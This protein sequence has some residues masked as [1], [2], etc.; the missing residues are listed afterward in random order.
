M[1]GAPTPTLIV[2]SFGAS[3]GGGSITSPIPKASTGVPG[4]ASYDT[5]FPPITMI[6]VTAG[7]V[8]PFGQDFNGI[9]KDLSSNIAALTGGQQYQF[10]AAF[11]AANGGYASGAVL[12]NA[13]NPLAYWIN[14]V[15]GNSNNPDTGGTGWVSGEIAIGQTL[16][17]AAAGSLVAAGICV[18]G[19]VDRYIKNT[20]PGS[21]DTTGSLTPGALTGWQAAT[22]QAI[23]P[24]GADVTWDGASWY[25]TT[26]PVNCTFT[27][28]G[29]QVGI[30]LYPSGGP[31]T[32]AGHGILAN[33]TGVAV[34]DFTGCSKAALMWAA[35]RTGSSHP[36]TAVL[37]ARGASNQSSFNRMLNCSIVGSFTDSV[38]YN[39]G[40]EQNIVQG[41]ILYN[42]ST[43]AG[44]C[45]VRL[46]ANNMSGLTSPYT[47]IFS[48]GLSTTCHYHSGNT[49]VNSAGTS[50][51]DCVVFD[52]I[53]GA[54]F[55]ECF[56]LSASSSAAGRAI[57]YVYG[58]N[59]TS[60]R[61]K[62]SR[63]QG[64]V[65]TFMHNYGVLF[66]NSSPATGNPQ[67]V[68]WE[69]C[70]SRLTN[71]LYAIACA[72]TT[73]KPTNLF[74]RN[75]TE[76]P[77]VAH[78]MN[79]PGVLLTSFIEDPALVLTIGTSQQ[80]CLI[81]DSNKWGIGTAAVGGITTR[82]NDNWC[83]TGAVNKTWTPALG[84]VTQSGTFAVQTASWLFTGSDATFDCELNSTGTFT[85][86]AGQTIT[87][88]VVAAAYASANVLICD[89]TSGALLAT[90][91][92]AAGTTAIKCTAFTTSS[93]HSIVIS[94][95][96][97]VA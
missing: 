14:M 29:N 41:N 60:N 42:L 34:F 28:G 67:P 70:D 1:A 7:G 20:T 48:G 63:M 32:D 5:G 61:I 94:G 81:G 31:A 12:Q 18:P 77:S 9:L 16:A 69:I 92:I 33:H 25:L 64:E 88:L 58:V 39:F 11:A 66:D 65:A 4:R 91:F 79:I 71:T 47:T 75:I 55:D 3:A 17:E 19:Y 46:T 27:G 40:A 23:Q 2:E 51:S 83:D 24:G 74:V 52:S 73:C 37:W 87:G 43:A 72:G 89:A 96:Y 97:K 26:A 80:N 36:Q 62:I 10:S 84:T 49:Y 82:T 30:K 53:D 15:S 50:T 57:F 38:I 13:S 45:V 59:A 93:G 86:T 85:A 21:T 8:N 78:G 95:R 56:A 35:I 6:P 76:Q 54:T 68:G 22:A 44:T 90:G